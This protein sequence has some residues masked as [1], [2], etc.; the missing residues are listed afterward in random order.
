MD[1]DA[2]DKRSAEIGFDDYARDNLW[3]LLDDQRA[4]TTAVPSDTTL[5]V[6]RFRDELGDWR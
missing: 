1:R 5:L 4:A 6:E 3:Q 2:F